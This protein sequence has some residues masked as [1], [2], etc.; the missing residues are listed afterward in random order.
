MKKLILLIPIIFIKA[1]IYK[2]S[3]VIIIVLLA[4]GTINAIYHELTKEKFEIQS[5]NN[6]ESLYKYIRSYGKHGAVYCESPEELYSYRLIETEKRTYMSFT[7]R[8]INEKYNK[9]SSYISRYYKYYEVD[10]DGIVLLCGWR[11]NN[12]YRDNDDSFSGKKVKTRSG[13]TNK[14]L[15]FDINSFTDI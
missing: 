7:C 2:P 8:P 11:D 1:M 13:T 5:I 4:F 6:K 14:C 9:Y 12:I 15:D 3:R 10:Q